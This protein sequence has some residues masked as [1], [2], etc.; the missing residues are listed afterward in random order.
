MA[1]DFMEN[2]QKRKLQDVFGTLKESRV[3]HIHAKAGEVGRQ[4]KSRFFEQGRRQI[5]A[6]GR[7][8]GEIVAEEFVALGPGVHAVERRIGELV[9]VVPK[10]SDR[11][12]GPLRQLI[13]VGVSYGIRS[14][15]IGGGLSQDLCS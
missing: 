5:E 4:A 12:V 2:L 13:G 14:I 9:F 1:A 3:A 6:G 7:Q 15:S 10:P 11:N 8:F